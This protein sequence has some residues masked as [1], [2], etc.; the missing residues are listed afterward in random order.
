[1][2]PHHKALVLGA[3]GL[4]GSMLLPLL[5]DSDYYNK[6]TVLT[7]K[8]L[9]QQ[10]PKLSAIE[11]DLMD[12]ES[13]QEHFKEAI[14][15]VCIGTT[16]AKTPDKKTYKAIDYGIPVQAAQIGASV[17]AKAILVISAMGADAE[18]RVFY[19]RI[20][21]EMEV[22]VLQAGLPD[23]FLFR[24][25]LIEGPREEFRFGEKMASVVMR[26]INP[27]IPRA[28]RPIAAAT[29]AKAML[30]VSLEGHPNTIIESAAIKDL[31]K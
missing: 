8:P 17:G 29:I 3:T 5:L 11:G 22:A 1:M 4:T 31:T 7:R 13:Y 21:G 24:P 16:Q 14:I 9:G 12:L 6:V 25:A 2:N 26:I 20:K 19:N 27:L 10:H 30:R 23:T 28:Y 15:F 18:S